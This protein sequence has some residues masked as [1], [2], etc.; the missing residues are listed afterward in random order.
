MTVANHPL[1]DTEPCRSTFVEV[2]VLTG[3]A[4]FSFSVVGLAGLL[5]PMWVPDLLIILLGIPIFKAVIVFSTITSVTLSTIA[6]EFPVGL[7]ELGVVEVA[8]GV[9]G[10]HLV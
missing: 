1:V 7:H 8:G 3:N 5:A 9:D 10:E 2:R 4:M 6:P